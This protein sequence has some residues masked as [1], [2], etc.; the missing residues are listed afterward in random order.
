MRV[1][2]D[3]I[4]TTNSNG[5]ITPKVPVQ[6]NGAPMDPGASFG[7]TVSIGGVNLSTLTGKDLDVERKGN[8][9][10]IHGHY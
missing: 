4:F 8:V 7:G 2:F 6:I 9:T 10:I 3:K 5:Y 1:P